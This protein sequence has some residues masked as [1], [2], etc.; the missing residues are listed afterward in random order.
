MPCV[1]LK[2]LADRRQAARQRRAAVAASRRLLENK[3]GSRTLLAINTPLR[4]AAGESVQLR[5]HRQTSVVNLETGS[6]KSRRLA[7]KQ[8][9]SAEKSTRKAAKKSA[10]LARREQKTA[11][12]SAKHPTR[13]DLINAESRLCSKLFGTIPAGHRR[14]FFHDRDNIWIWH[15]GWTDESHRTRQLTVRYEVRPNGVFKKLSAGKYLK[16]EGA[17]L[18]NFRRATHAYLKVIKQELYPHARTQ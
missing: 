5:P 18:E 2:S 6:K 13:A 10:K 11:R 8:Q 12:R 14:E 7:K 1:S 3:I 9:K 4:L 15:E 16:L 17:E